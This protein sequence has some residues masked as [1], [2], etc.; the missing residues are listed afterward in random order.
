MSRP[1]IA[2]LLAS[3][4]AVPALAAPVEPPRR[5]RVVVSEDASLERLLASGLDVV[6][7]RGRQ[8]ELLV[9]PGDEAR[10]VAL[11]FSATLID[12][13][14]GMTAAAAARADW[15]RMG[16]RA[17]A[18]DRAGREAGT[19]VAPPY[20]GGSMA[21]YWTTAEIK[22]K[23][24]DLVA[25]DALDLVANQ[26]DTV[27]YS[28]QGRPVWGLRIAKTVAGPDT[29]PVVFFNALT[30]AREPGGMQT[31][32][33][34]V[35]QLLSRYG[36]DPYARYL[37]ENRVIYIVP[38]V[39]PD[40][41]AVNENTYFN[42]GG[43]TL[44]YW[45]KNTRDNNGNNS[46]DPNDGVDLNRN[47]GVQWNLND[48]GSSPNPIDETYRGPAAFSEPETQVQRDLVT[49]LQPK[50]AFSFHTYSDLLIHP[51]GY[52]TTPTGDG[53]AF[54]E[55]GDEL[56][57]SNGYVHGAAPRILYEVNGEF[58]DWCY[59]DT[60]LKPRVFSWTP[61]VGA[62][63]DGNFW[64]APSKIVP[65]ATRMLHSCYVLAGIAGTFVQEDGITIT[66]GAM[67]AGRLTNLIVRARNLGLATTGPGLNGTLLPIDL[68]ANILNGVVS[69]PGLGTRQSADPVGTSRF[70]IALD[71]TVTPGRLMRFLV[72]F[73]DGAGLYSR[74]TLVIPAGTP[75]VVFQDYAS[76][77]LGFW[78]PALWSIVSGDPAHASAYFTDSPLGDYAAAADNRFY[79]KIRLNLSAGV[80][81]HALYEARW[82]IEQDYDG[83]AVEATSDTAAIPFAPVAATGTIPGSGI[84]VQTAGQPLY[85]GARYRWRPEIADLSAF[86]GPGKTNVRLRF[87]LRSDS[88]GEF[89]G[90]AIDSLRIVIY[91]PA[92]QPGPVS[93]DP[94]VPRALALSAPAPNP[95]RGLVRFDLDLPEEGSVRFEILDIA[96]RRVR[97]LHD[98]PLGAGAWT[99]GWDLTEDSGRRVAPGIYFARFTGAAGSAMRRLVVI[100]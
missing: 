16:V 98:G 73:R 91:N 11:G 89:D 85:T 67:N 95:T 64:P 38:L 1:L 18:R 58:N 76:S 72:E 3:L 46:F 2:V 75:T 62:F 24:D 13:H 88:G 21:G 86:T 22:A 29:R 7:V 31:L 68:G 12:E 81:A 60:L 43:T 96:G 17:P 53:D 9:R 15:Q 80:H 44:G 78:T 10:L 52:T 56:S 26:I 99:Q 50:T 35:D 94:A 97:T 59:G 66:E 71:D 4:L 30:H 84:G 49:L 6:N 61:E 14:P 28:T 57:R 37:L 25:G 90:M 79:L 8:V 83:V 47:Y 45:R 55:W 36:T 23:L 100:D 39:N 27:G 74:D 51:W 54:D 65:I 5:M 20:G 41:Y 77:G 87:R 69:Y 92:A 93:V 42:S 63:E 32:F 48:F 70:Q 34:F 19:L 82:Q 33:Y 40:G